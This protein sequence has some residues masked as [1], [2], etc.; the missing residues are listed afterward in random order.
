MIRVFVFQTNEISFRSTFFE[1]S[2][3]SSRT[4][5]SLRELSRR[6]TPWRQLLM[7]KRLLEISIWLNVRMGNYSMIFH[8]FRTLGREGRC[9]HLNS[10]PFCRAPAPPFRASQSYYDRRSTN[11]GAVSRIHCCSYALR[12]KDEVLEMHCGRRFEDVNDSLAEKTFQCMLSYAPTERSAHSNANLKQTL[13][14]CAGWWYKT[15]QNFIWKSECLT[16]I[17][18]SSHRH[19]DPPSMGDGLTCGDSFASSWSGSQ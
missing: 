12:M 4:L 5:W 16:L 10:F 15:I 18:S 6:P 8:K 9:R 17:S 11:I 1:N 19:W 14:V 7:T 2:L 13:R 3:V